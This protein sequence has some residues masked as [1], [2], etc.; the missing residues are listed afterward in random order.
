MKVEIVKLCEKAKLPIKATVGSAGFDLFSCFEEDEIMIPTQQ[1]KI[2]GTGVSI[3]IPKCATGMVCSR[4][5]LAAK[6]GIAVLNSPGI[7][8][9]DYRGEV[10]VILI[11]LSSEP[12]VVE[13]NMR[14]AQLLI[15]QH[16]VYVNLEEKFSHSSITERGDCGFGSTGLK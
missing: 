1:T 13:K 6:Y 12:F 14:I 2:V 3:A 16:A 9:S 7:I 10:K 11:N 5:G 15:V 8:D 4:S